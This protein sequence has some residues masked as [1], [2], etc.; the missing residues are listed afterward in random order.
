M[1]Y[2]MKKKVLTFVIITASSLEIATGP[3]APVSPLSP[4]GP[5]LPD[6]P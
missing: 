6:T 1:S 4:L 3:G 2:F 5:V